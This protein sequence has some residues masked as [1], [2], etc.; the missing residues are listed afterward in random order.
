M[1]GNVSSYSMHTRTSCA[2]R[3][4]QPNQP[5]GSCV[6][7]SLCRRR[8]SFQSVPFRRAH[9]HVFHAFHFQS[10]IFPNVHLS[11]LQRTRPPAR[12]RPYM[13]FHRVRPRKER[14]LYCIPIY[15]HRRIQKTWE[16]NQPKSQIVRYKMECFL[17]RARAF[18]ALAAA[19]ARMHSFMHVDVSVR[20]VE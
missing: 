13:H 11:P 17:V 5:E 16:N 6:A 1:N 2:R 10:I 14:S 15:I 19:R 3:I 18:R 12:A 20:R 8:H 4:T 9:A 7:L